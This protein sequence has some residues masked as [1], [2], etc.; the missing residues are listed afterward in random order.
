[1]TDRLEGRAQAP[2]RGVATSG[3]RPALLVHEYVTGGG[4]PEADPPRFAGEADAMVRAV[5][6]DLRDWGRFTVVTTRDRRVG[7]PALP[8]DRVVW[9]DGGGPA[10]ELPSVAAPPSA[11]ASE[12]APAPPSAPPRPPA[13]LPTCRGFGSATT[14]SPNVPR[15]AP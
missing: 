8:A 10:A 7:G 5:L 15:A 4:W 13:R 12:P 3:D 1:M 6:E 9:L 2:G 11:P 14:R